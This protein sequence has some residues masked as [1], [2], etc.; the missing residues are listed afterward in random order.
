VDP[1]VAEE[2]EM[3]FDGVRELCRVVTRELA[4][5]GRLAP[6]L[7]PEGEAARLHALLDG[8][9]V[10]GLMGRLDPEGML[11]V[12]DAHLDEILGEG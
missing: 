5:A 4:R 1:R 7:D 8:L 11:G 10:H 9:C 12:L 3:V 2:H 6:G